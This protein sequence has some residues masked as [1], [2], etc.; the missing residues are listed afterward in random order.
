MDTLRC[1]RSFRAVA[2]QASFIAASNRLDQSAAMT[3]KHVMHLENRLGVRLLNRNSRNVSLTDAGR[4]YLAQLAQTLDALDET[5]AAISETS[6]K[7]KGLLR[8]SA[9]VWMACA[10]FAAVLTEFQRTYPDVRIDIDLTG[11]LVDLVEEGVDIALRVS[12]SLGENY[13]AREVTE[14]S[15][16]WVASPDYCNRMGQPTNTR[17]LSEH[18]V[19]WY[20][21]LP[22]EFERATPN[23]E[24]AESVRLNPV[25]RSGNETLLHSAALGGMGLA[26][27]PNWV[28]SPDLASGRLIRVFND[29]FSHRRQV[30]AV[31]SSRKHLSSKVRVFIDFLMKSSFF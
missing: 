20:S 19:L 18:S 24:G 1:M 21:R 7:P 9:P 2:E 5:E 16:E 15:F 23:G 6:Y 13:I 17:E 28:T 12:D 11:R 8:I 22:E 29:Q 27:L 3:S 25:L 14:V 30:F 10:G 31:Y 26:L 4:E